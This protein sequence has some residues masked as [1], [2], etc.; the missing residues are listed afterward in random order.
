MRLQKVTPTVTDRVT[1]I[2]RGAKQY[3]EWHRH[4]L[5]TI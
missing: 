5:Q 3:C 2:M 4:C 1:M